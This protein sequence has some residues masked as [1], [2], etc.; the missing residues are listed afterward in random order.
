MKN[1][2]LLHA[3][4][5][6]INFDFVK[7]YASTSDLKNMTPNIDHDLGAERMKKREKENKKA[8]EEE[9]KQEPIDVDEKKQSKADEEEMKEKQ[10]FSF[11][12]QRESTIAYLHR[13]MPY[14]YFVY[15]RL[16]LEIQKRLPNFKAAT[17]LD[18]GAGLGSGAW[19]ANHVFG[20]QV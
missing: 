9:V 19:A 17:V 11:N 14:H 20:D 13:K 7:P 4:E 1:Y 5:K 3:I 18:Y 16:M 2:Q 10:Q 12:Y 6:P 15:K 8:K